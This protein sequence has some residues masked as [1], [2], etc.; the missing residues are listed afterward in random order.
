[1]GI[2][3]DRANETGNS[4]EQ[5]FYDV[6]YP[7]GFI[8][9]DA[10]NGYKSIAYND[11]G[12][13]YEV[14]HL[15]I[16]DGSYTKLI[17]RS[18]S[19]KSTFAVQ[20]GFNIINQFPDS[21]MLILSLEGGITIPRLE[22]LTGLIGEDLN[23][24]VKFRNSDITAESI[25]DEI[26]KIYEDKKK[27]ANNLLYDTGMRDSKGLPIMKF[28]PTVVI[29]DSIPMISPKRIAD[30]GELTGQMSATAMAK[31]NTALFKG[32]MQLIKATNIIILAVNH[33][34]M[35]IE[36]GPYHTKGD[37][38]FLKQGESLPGGRA[39]TYLAN[40]IVRFDDS[41]LKE[42]TFGFSG[43][44]VAISLC[45][46]RTNKAGKATPLIFN[47]EFGFDPIYSLFI[48][49]KECGRIITRGAYLEL[50]GFP[51]KFRTRDLKELFNNDS[52]FATLFIKA[53]REET[54][55]LL[56]PIPTSS[57]SNNAAVAKNL[58]E[59]FR[60]LEA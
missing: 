41:K 18:G 43:A 53:V 2:I 49:L 10:L 4:S 36:S 58:I 33:I 42:E 29:I 38:A 1:M 44:E 46:S 52:D 59:S 47:Q 21:D 50:E 24:R 19:G 5:A 26:Y 54:S 3:T 30:K 11:K 35:K 32:I 15:G 16:L 57:R 23:K 51:N 7:T 13:G 28:I 14:T 12:E 39:V 22:T 25:Y 40:N 6:C 20:A 37:L 48:M 45:K 34:T 8:N 56:A 55:K 27:N 17:G 60:A 31:A 9:F